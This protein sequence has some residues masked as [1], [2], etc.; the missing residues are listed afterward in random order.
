MRQTKRRLHHCKQSNCWSYPN[1]F[2]KNRL[3]LVFGLIVLKF[4]TVIV[5][6]EVIQSFGPTSSNWLIYVHKT[7]IHC[8]WNHNIVFVFHNWKWVLT[9]NSV[10]FLESRALL[11]NSNKITSITDFVSHWSRSNELQICKFILA[12]LKSQITFFDN[13]VEK[14]PVSLVRAEKSTRTAVCLESSCMK[15]FESHVLPGIVQVAFKGVLWLVYMMSQNDLRLESD[16][17]SRKFIVVAPIHTS[18][19][20]RI[21]LIR[22]RFWSF[23]TQICSKP[24]FREW[25]IKRSKRFVLHA[26]WILKLS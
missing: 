18:K 15:C 1:S 14:R 2:N 26:L 5:R 11:L 22:K 21:G 24:Y 6:A 23:R 9:D 7:A 12:N 10:C 19:R 13:L 3:D 8:L 20:P 16:Q 17:V 25:R 4:V